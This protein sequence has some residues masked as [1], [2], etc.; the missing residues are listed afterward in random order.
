MTD[1]SVSTSDP[2]SQTLLDVLRARTREAH[3]RLERTPLAL[4]L[5]HHTL[6]AP[7]LGAIL[8]V[9]LEHYE[10][11]LAGAGGLDARVQEVLRDARGWLRADLARV[12][13]VTPVEVV[14][15]GAARSAAQAMGEAYVLTGA[16]LG[17][18]SMAPKLRKRYGAENVS[19]YEG[20]GRETAAKWRQVREAIVAWGEAHKEAAAWDEAA[21][22]ASALF[23]RFEEAYLEE[24]PAAG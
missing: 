20:Y 3:E 23:A 7:R 6:E 10:R 2:A 17:A 11:A 1:A 8:R 19:F 21:A 15:E 24:M 14:G 22:G 4:A 9:H 13:G 12:E 18:V 16:L 5:Q